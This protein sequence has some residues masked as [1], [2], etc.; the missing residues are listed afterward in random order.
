MLLAIRSTTDMLMR[1]AF[2]MTSGVENFLEGVMRTDTQDFL[3]KMEGFA[4][5]GIQGIISFFVNPTLLDIPL[6]EWHK[7]T[8]NEFQ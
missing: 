5:Q 7:I 8:S 4:V 6:Q 3:G 2:F 1:G